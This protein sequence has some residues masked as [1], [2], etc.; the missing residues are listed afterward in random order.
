MFL[1]FFAKLSLTT[2][3]ILFLVCTSLSLQAT[4]RRKRPVAHIIHRG[5]AAE[6]CVRPALGLLS[7]VLVIEDCLFL[8]DKVEEACRYGTS[9]FVFWVPPRTG[10]SGD[11]TGGQQDEK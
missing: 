1:Q 4:H 2:S 5:L 3:H 11:G 6:E 9:H 10:G 8:V 7:L